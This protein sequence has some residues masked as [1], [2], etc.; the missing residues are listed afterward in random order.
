MTIADAEKRLG[1]RIKNICGVPVEDL[2]AEANYTIEEEDSALNSKDKVYNQIV[3]F[4]VIEGYPSE[5][6][7]D[8]NINDLVYA[9]ISPVIFDFIGKTGRNGMQLLREKEIISVD[10]ETGGVEFVMVDQISVTEEKVVFIIEAKRTPIGQAMEQC[11]LSLKDARDGNGAAVVYGFVTTGEH[12]RMLRS[13]G[14]S[15]L[16]SRMITVVFDGMEKKKEPWM[17]E[18]S[19]LVDCLFAAL[20]NGGVTTCEYGFSTEMFM[21]SNLIQGILLSSKRDGAE[22]HVAKRGDCLLEG[23]NIFIYRCTIVL[24][25]N[26][27]SPMSEA[28]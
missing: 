24:D 22:P 12:W 15:F 19:M 20:S 16:K 17:K 11:L 7:P 9:T 1:I 23:G 21:K 27:R 14:T 5:E 2:L 25:M 13:D 8:F 26:T 18:C 3:Q 6:N 28:N 4:L 10:S